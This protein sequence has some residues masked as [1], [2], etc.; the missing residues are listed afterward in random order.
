MSFDQMLTL[1]G[2][3]VTTIVSVAAALDAV[4]PPSDDP[5]IGRI[6]KL[7]SFIA[8][9]FG[10]STNIAPTQAAKEAAK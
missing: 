10:H 8:L 2:S 7:V 4:L 9:N 6:K 1:A 3:V 5:I